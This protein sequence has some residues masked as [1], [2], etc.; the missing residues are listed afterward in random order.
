M[1]YSKNKSTLIRSLS[2]FKVLSIALSAISPTTSVFL[3]YGLCLQEAGS[4]LLIS[5]SIGSIIAISMAFC[6]AELGVLYPRTG[7]AYS[8]I[9]SVLGSSI[10]YGSSIIFIS[11]G[12]IISAT[13]VDAAAGFMHTLLPVLPVHLVEFCM[14]F[15]V[16]IFALVRI[17]ESSIIASVMVFVEISVIAGFTIGGFW[18]FW[19]KLGD[20]FM[21]NLNSASFFNIGSNGV[22]LAIVPALFALNGY[23][24][25]LYFSEEVNDPQKNLPKAVIY[26]VFLAVSIEILAVISAT[27]SIHDINIILNS[28]EPLAAIA[29]S[30]FGNEGE[31]LLIVGVI[32]AMFDA[33]L[34]SN[35]AFSRIYLDIS[36]DHIWPG[37]INC[38]M[39]S[40]NHNNVPKWS[41]VFI[42]FS[43]F[44]VCML[45]PMDMLI[46]II[47]IEILIIYLLIA[48]SSVVSRLKHGRSTNRFSMP[49][50]PLMPLIAFVGI[51]FAIYNQPVILVTAIVLMITL[52][53]VYDFYFRR[54]KVNS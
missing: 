7:G 11:L 49:L 21:V 6:Y 41:I 34:S 50:W 19:Y 42:G 22:L 48:T 37:S 51:V 33:A 44:F 9:T 8:I 17:S 14:V 45:V 15:L 24:W 5:F 36:R 2:F 10:G 1:S 43:N 38:M 4:K 31:I 26:A 46:N 40:I 47:G 39:S 23:D 30:I 20:L 54:K 29:K 32:V 27:I 16:T 28:T 25:P 53:V 35:L 52:F 3:V 12:I 13:F 18:L